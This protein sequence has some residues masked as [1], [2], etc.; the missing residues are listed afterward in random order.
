MEVC[1]LTRLA[2]QRDRWAFFNN[3]LRP[4]NAGSLTNRLP[5]KA[6]GRVVG[7]PLAAAQAAQTYTFQDFIVAADTDPFN[8]NSTNIMAMNT[9]GDKVGNFMNGATGN[10]TVGFYNNTIINYSV[11][12]NDTAL[13]G[14][15]NRGRLS[16]LIIT[17]ILGI[18]VLCRPAP[19]ALKPI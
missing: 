12:T 17:L 6:K 16:V 7:E 19:A 5:G 10:S 4:V 3:L 1:R 9:N 18:L 14:I 15:N 11:G 2:A 13:T 8:P